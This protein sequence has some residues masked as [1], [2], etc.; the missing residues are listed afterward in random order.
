MPPISASVIR[1]AA[2]ALL[3]VALSLASCSPAAAQGQTRPAAN[4]SR[5]DLAQGWLIQSS[6]KVPQKGDEL[7]AG[8]FQ[9]HDWYPASIPSTVV[10]ALVDNKVYPDP[11]FGMN[12]RSF[13]GTS[14][15]VGQNFSNSATPADSP[16]AV[17][18]WY[19]T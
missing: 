9:P 7:S 14:Y 12:L 1:K 13:P 17:S 11:Y 16:F 8:K 18:W 19:R 3:W 4:G 15:N 5:I 10:A 2:G 6:A